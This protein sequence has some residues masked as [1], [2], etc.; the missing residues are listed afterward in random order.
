[1]ATAAVE[2]NDN[3]YK[4]H[5]SSDESE[6]EGWSDDEIIFRRGQTLKT[7]PMSAAFAAI[8]P[9]IEADQDDGW[10]KQVTPPLNIPFCF[11]R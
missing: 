11:G 6:F 10:S 9:E 5:S 1:M 7:L 4:F 3:G 2:E 8:D